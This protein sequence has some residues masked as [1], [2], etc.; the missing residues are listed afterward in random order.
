VKGAHR[1][2]LMETVIDF[3]PARHYYF[4][5]TRRAN[6]MTSQLDRV[7]AIN[8]QTLKRNHFPP[9]RIVAAILAALALWSG[10]AGAAIA[11]QNGSTAVT[12]TA[13]ATGSMSV[14]VTA[15]A[16]VLVVMVEDHGAYDAEPATLSWNGATLNLAVQSDPDATTYRGV[17]IYYLFNPPAGT[18]TL[19]VTVTGADNTWITA[20]TLNGVSTGAAPLT[21]GTNSVGTAVTGLT[22]N[23][24]GVASGSWAAVGASYA[25]TNATIAIS[26]TGGTPAFSSD[27]VDGGST[28]TAGYVSGLSAGTVT[29][30]DTATSTNG[31][32]KTILAEAVFTPAGTGGAVWTGATSAIW[33]TATANWIITPPG[34]A[35]DYAD[36]D[37]V[38][39][40]DAGVSQFGVNLA[41]T[42]A[43]ASVTFSNSLHNY[44]I[45][46]AGAIGGAG[47]LTLS[48]AGAVTLNVSNTFT[49]GVTVGAGATLNL[50]GTNTY[51]GTT[52][53]GT[54]ATLAI[55]G[56]GDLGNGTYAAAISD[57][58]TLSFNSTT[59]QILTGSI[60]GTGGV[61]LAGGTLTLGNNSLADEAYTG[62][63][64]VANGTLNLNFPNAGTSGIYKSSGLT[65]NNGGMVAAMQSSALEGYTAATPYLPVT[66]NAGGTLA[67][68]GTS[69]FGCH[70]FGVLNLNGGT[71]AM[72]GTANATYAGWEI[73]NQINVN[74]GAATSTLSA[75]QMGPQQSG[76]TVF[77]ITSGGTSQTIPGVDLIVTGTFTNS[78]G[79]ADTGIIL[80]GSGVMA[81][82]GGS[83]DIAHGI[84]IGSGTTL[85]LTNAATIYGPG[86][87]TNNGTFM[88]GSP[89]AQT[90]SGII[91]G[92]GAVEV[93]AS[94]AAL[95]LN[96]ADTYSGNTVISAGTLLLG[97]A[98]SI[99]NTPNISIS[100]GATFDVSALSSYT[101]GAN[102]SL[103]A[104]GTATP[105]SVK[106][107]VSFGSRP[108]TLNYDGSHPALAIPS[109]TLTL[110]GNAFAV[111]G[112]PLSDGN[113]TL[114]Q[115]TTG[116]ITVSGT[117]PAPTGTAIPPAV[118]ATISVSGGNVVLTIGKMIPVITW[119]T[120]AAIPY[121][122]ALG[123]SQLDATASVSG[124]FAYTPPLG[125]ILN[126][127]AN[128]LS[129]LFTPTDTTDYSSA[130]Q[131]V[132]LVV[133][134][135]PLTVSANNTNRQYGQTNP[136]FTGTLAG[137][138]NG[139]NITA[140]YSC[141]ATASSPVGTYPIVPI[142]SDP[143]SRLGNYAVTTND[144]TLTI[145]PTSGIQF[146]AP[147][148]L[149]ADDVANPV[150]TE[151]V[152][153][154]G[155]LDSDTNANEIQTA[156]EILVASSPAN[157]NNNIG[158]M[159]DSGQ[160]LSDRENHVV[161]AGATA[162]TADTEYYWKVRVW[163]REGVASPYSASATFTVGLL[164][165]GD[166]S[167]ASWIVG[168]SSPSDDYTYFRKTNAVLAATS[169]QRAT[170]YITSVHK[171]VLYVNGMLVGKGPAFAFQPY[172][173]YNAYDITGLVT[174]GEA[175][176]FAIMNHWFGSGSGRPSSSPGV[177]MKAVIHYTDGTSTN[178]V[179][180]GT[181]WFQSQATNWATGQQSRGSAGYVEKIYA[182]SLPTNWFTTTLNPAGW[183]APTV[184][185]GQ[186]NSTWPG[187]LLP[188][189][190]RIVETVY[191]PVSV[192]TLAGNVYL[193]D[194]GRL[195]SGVPVI[196]FSSGGSSGT[197][198]SMMGGFAL[199][200]SGFI[201]PSQNQSTV[202]ND[203]AV[204]NGSPFTY[205]PI[206]YM[207]MRYFEI[208]NPPMA[209]TT[210]N[211]WFVERHSLMNDASSSFASPN[212]TLNN[213]WEL[214]KETAPIDAQEEFIDS[215][216]QEGGFLGDGFQES[217][218]AMEVQDERPLT[219]RRLN[220]FIES[221]V[222]FWSTPATNV[223]RVNACY[224]DNENARDIPDYTEMFLDWVW[225]YYMQT[226]DLAFLGTNYTQLTNIAQYVNR[227]LNP[228]TGLITNLCGG[229]Q[230]G[231][232]SGS[233]EYGI[234][235]W[236]PDMQF[237]YDLNTVR[238]SGPSSATVIN[239]WAWEDYDIVSRIA[240]ELGNTTDSNTYRTLAN[241]L[242]TAINSKLINASGL[243]TDGLDG[244]G[245]Q[246]THTSQHANAFPLSLNIVPPA[247]EAGAAALIARSNMNVSALGILQLVRGLGEA[248]Q[249]P[250]LL[251]LYTNA[252]N[253]GWAQILSF[254]GSAT[255]ESWTANTD[256]NSES[257]GWGD[258]GID[259]YV[260]YILGV[261]P[262]TPQFAQVQ[263][264]PL[265]F[266][267][268]LTNISGT[269]TT[270]RGAISV[271]WDRGPALYH[272]AVTIP[273]NV[274]AS[275]YVPQAGLAGASVYVDGTNVTGTLTNLGVTPN[276]YGYV[277]VS[278]LG[279]GTHNIQRLLAA[280]PPASLTAIP[281]NAQITLVWT[282]PVGATNYVILRGTSSGHET[283][284]V[285]SGVTNTNYTDTG[286][287]DGDT[288]YYV[289]AANSPLGPSGN[290][291]EA[292]ATPV[293]GVL[294][295]TDGDGT[296]N[297]SDALN[298]SVSAGAAPPQFPGDS[299]NFGT[300][301]GPVTLD[302]P[303]TVGAIT[304][305]S[306]ASYTISGANTLTV[307]NNGNGAVITVTAGAANTI[308]T[309]I[310]L[311]DALETLVGNGDSLTF[312][313]NIGNG[314]KGTKPLT[315]G[316]L[317]ATILDGANTYTGATTITAGTLA[318]GGG[319]SL[320][321][322]G[323]NLA[324]GAT[325]DVS[326]QAA[327]S[328]G[329]ATLAASGSAAAAANIH[330]QTGGTVSLGSVP[331]TLTC[332]GVGP[333]LTLSQGALLL[334]G[335]AF[336]INA[337]GG[338][339]LPAG[340]YN[341]VQQTGGVINGAVAP[342]VAGT[343]IPAS[344]TTNFLAVNG[345]NVVLTILNAT[346]ITLSGGVS[347]ATY[348]APLSIRAAVSP[349]PPNGETLVFYAGAVPIL[350]TA[351]TGGAA[352]LPISTLPAGTYLITAAYPGDSANAA[353]ASPAFS[354]TINPAA[355]TYA[356]SA[357]SQLY[358][359]A[360]TV[361]SGS[362]TGF[363]NGDTLSSATTG[364]LAF[365]SS[366]TAASPVGTYAV[367]GSGLSAN[368][369]TFAQAPGNA[370]AL[371]IT[372]LGGVT[373]VSGLTAA[374]KVY[375]ST[376]TASLIL[377]NTVVLAGLA[378]GD[379]SVGLSTNSYVAA[380]AGSNAAANI[381]VTVA[382][383]ALAGGDFS[384]YTLTQPVF[385]ADITP[386]PITIVSGLTVNPATYGGLSG[387]DEAEL[388]S[389][390][391][392][393]TGIFDPDIGEVYLDTNAYAA[394]FTGTNASPAVPVTVT[395][396]CLEGSRAA[397]YSL[398]QPALTGAI[399]PASLTITADSLYKTAGLDNPP[400]TAS[401]SGFVYSDTSA[402]LATP[403]TLSTAAT[404]A[405]PPGAYPITAGD[406]AD[407]NYNMSY[408]PGTLTVVAPPEMEG[409]SL[410]GAL[411]IFSYPAVAGQTY[412]LQSATNINSGV[413]LPVGD[414]VPGTGATV[415]STNSLDYT[416]Q[417]FFRLSITR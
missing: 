16:S 236:P 53:I 151:A 116:S 312:A 283:T 58:G 92:T 166:W 247:N 380:F 34:T 29:F 310:S 317:G 32:Q 245:A 180:D 24:T 261:K 367:T 178:I 359:S 115:Q 347:P 196:N 60:S 278:G 342:A 383:L 97:A 262:L 176:Q 2:G 277:G 46:G 214:M 109:G 319:A 36:G 392:V 271:E 321:T 410:S 159:W 155:W 122:A 358:G 118:T 203:F 259:G 368:N 156:Y 292:H 414:P 7:I 74:G 320:A 354:Q 255:W 184:I 314:A 364:T 276:G 275:V 217:I 285:A 235:D 393:L 82:A 67:T 397:N 349:A 394:A 302:A 379:S 86:L 150:G 332:D 341:V 139:D 44:T 50:N 148:N 102:A 19:S 233:Y 249:G 162:L 282:P 11:L 301:A 171:Y 294:T 417:Q 307:D 375:D 215:M 309:A 129:V 40:G 173:F 54:G 69:G 87:I 268:I 15:G 313:G 395:G 99:N 290:S 170:A 188:D 357:S 63:T 177:L 147:T 142:F 327:F 78:S 202:M 400:L 25:T 385:S 405:S 231:V 138:V 241:N 199:L 22:N 163:D 269:L 131:T 93:N 306:S 98:G 304:F 137:V 253:Y 61:T 62:P 79:A 415:F 381:T 315:A 224:P 179:T 84:T 175:N 274:T 239:G 71:L 293:P 65:I 413:W 119:A 143:N 384:N 130:T 85:L 238:G 95:T 110:D 220:E 399:N 43:P 250:A 286:L 70:L 330:G 346:A 273:V 100:A 194:M 201:D 352:S 350:T 279:S 389:N 232:I 3:K 45:S 287:T 242:Q 265:D 172:Q 6:P 27:L 343:A 412:Q 257:H 39:F 66:I 174:N 141:V 125:T 328:F 227:D 226:G 181:S 218:T 212:A 126:A 149:L 208:T 152:P 72:S 258:V 296:G 222:E 297:W 205:Q 362:V 169:V 377:T 353:S 157:L 408:V 64:T 114:I 165:N 240:G 246:S 134:T 161:Y 311:N 140:N 230:N 47:A 339:P 144:G 298:W 305:N 237:G 83:N 280:I 225:E 234:I 128:T 49:G 369:Y 308:Q 81:L 42:V 325:F 406:A 289:V 216:R 21:F 411:L 360:N 284:T 370:T 52:T 267:N 132:S 101:L 57:N 41:S 89:G 68:S 23:V 264:M 251:N 229:T 374:D 90:L 348:G 335:N 333:A 207:T 228:A 206:T 37:T 186:P 200:S 211:F 189:L 187:P 76:G 303:E 288:Y 48:G 136:V 329:A 17:A 356:A 77:N 398:L 124:S 182:G 18:A 185:G 191:T 323:I 372:P 272:L 8:E 197:T 254:G 326:S 209:V 219:R 164:V 204:L 103:T 31:A 382:G 30:I 107:I 351:I 300:G 1:T 324:G 183:A 20:Y 344:G 190:T 390:N 322:S 120:P 337:L 266:T 252:N 391:V 12:H 108:V 9:R 260:R 195:H 256:G 59:A 133:S 4:T 111:N 26:G 198:I 13:G 378:G 112:S 340:S 35:G 409:I 387:L 210:N 106:G 14:T 75:Q 94:G 366:T 168:T 135:A 355:L 117:F 153:Y 51:A 371:T 361:F 291:P 33:D 213:V 243:Y 365:N 248:N 192:T 105:A 167:G 38:G 146:F 145:T 221:M 193:V 407:A 331:V 158:D 56:A 88:D 55:G 5:M 270:D 299:A 295:W 363:V 73:D 404:A 104:G 223:G 281:G 121:G 154:F 127:G 345:A 244:G 96:A 91:S 338:S 80:T 401:Y 10:R 416:G 396:L 123:A 386:A 263:I 388:S 318:L 402:S 336:T 28:M 160:V 376:D 316:G 334:S 373:V 113:Y 403:P